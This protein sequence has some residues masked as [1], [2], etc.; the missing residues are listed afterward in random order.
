MLLPFLVT[1]Q[2]IGSERPRN[3][4]GPAGTRPAAGG[5]PA[6]KGKGYGGKGIKPKA[7]AKVRTKKTKG[8]KGVK[9]EDAA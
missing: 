8:G 9:D 7:K 6:Q 1:H 4:K 5:D 3:L 2:A